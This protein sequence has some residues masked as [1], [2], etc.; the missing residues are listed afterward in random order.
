M[1]NNVL[2]ALHN[3]VIAALAELGLFTDLTWPGQVSFVAGR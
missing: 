3:V 2:F 1:N